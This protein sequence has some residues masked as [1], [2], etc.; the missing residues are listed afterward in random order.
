[1]KRDF[2]RQSICL[3]LSILLLGRM[4]GAGAQ[5]SRSIGYATDSVRLRSRPSSSAT[6]LA[7][8]QKG[9]AVLVS[10]SEDTYYSV[11]YEGQMGFVV[12]AF[13]NVETSQPQE[14]PALSKEEASNYTALSGGSTGAAVKALQEALAELRFYT[15]SVDSKYGRGTEQA[16]HAFQEANGLTASGT[17]DAASQALLFEGEPKDAQGVKTSVKT[18]PPIQGYTMRLG[19]RGDAVA[20]LQQKLKDLSFYKGLIDATFGSSTQTSVREFQRANGLGIDGIAGEETQARLNNAGIQIQTTQTPAPTSQSSI[21][22]TPLPGKAAYPY[23]TTTNAA[24]NLRKRAY[25]SAMRYLTIPQGGSIQVLEDS[26]SYLKV[27]YK[28]FIGY[29]DKDF[30]HIPEQY[31]EGKSLGISTDARVKYETLGVGSEGKKVRALQQALAELGFYS[32]TID[33]KFGAGTISALKA[34]Q[35]RNGLRETGTALPELQQL[36]FEKRIRNSRG[37]LVSIKTLPPVEGI[38][39]SL[40]DYGDAVYELHQMLVKVG[41]YDGAVGFEY[42]SSTAKA[43]SA[44]QKAHSIKVSG[45]ADSFTMLTA[46]CTTGSDTCARG[47]DHSH[48]FGRARCCGYQTADTPDGTGLLQHHTGWYIQ[49][50]RHRGGPPI[51][52]R[53]RPFCQQHGGPGYPANAI[54]RLCPARGFPGG[55]PRSGR[56]NTQDRYLRRRG[57]SDAVASDYTQIF[58]R[59]G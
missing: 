57:K 32:N 22:L 27:S 31:L 20:S 13:I 58:K 12:S 35:K 51:P 29:V 3:M 14:Q 53:Q 48:P 41:L 9:D 42:T 30:V 1:M 24:V 4:S 40:G 54:R 7:V 26:G 10:G 52:A 37:K 49:Q 59:H 38:T 44:F 25:A 21:F 6:I 19:D 34:F 43:V 5:T 45:R 16:V 23:S 55:R 15:M 33:G 50:R 39:M 18:L 56:R 11:E 8:I 46:G 28:E 36:L 47:H 17:A 2:F